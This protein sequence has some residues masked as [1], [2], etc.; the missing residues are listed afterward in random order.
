MRVASSQFVNVGTEL[1]LHSDK[2]QRYVIT[3]RASGLVSEV[4]VE[5]GKAHVVSATNESLR[6]D[7]HDVQAAGKGPEGGIDFRLTQV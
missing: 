7:A 3:G 2:A 1:R 6:V 5:A 4:V